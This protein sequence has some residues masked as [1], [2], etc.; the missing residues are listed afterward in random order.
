MNYFENLHI[1]SSKNRDLD[2]KPQVG[3]Y[4]KSG[5][6]SYYQDINK[7]QKFLVS[8]LYNFANEDLWLSEPSCLNDLD[9]FAL[10]Q[11]I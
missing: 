7:S 2:R 5:K 8:T 9:L 11:V 10:L 6:S 1:G 4:T 3:R